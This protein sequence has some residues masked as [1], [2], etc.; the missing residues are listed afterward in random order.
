MTHNRENFTDELRGFALLGIVLVNAPFLG[1]SIQGFSSASIASPLDYAAAFFTLAFAQAKFYLLFSF[2][3]GYS[4]S[5]FMKPNQIGNPWPFRRRLFGLGILG[6]VHALF[7]FV[8]DILMLYALLGA[9]LFLMRK[10]PDRAV[11]RICILFV[12]LWIGITAV[13]LHGSSAGETDA[14]IPASLKA[15]DVVM[16][17][18][19]FFEAAKARITVFPF[20]AIILT[21]FNGFGVLA[22]FCLGLIAGRHRLLANFAD[23]Q[24]LWRLGSRIGLLL[25]VPTGLLS[26]YLTIGP[27][28]TLGASTL[29]E[30][31][32]TVLG[33]V[34]A[35]LLT[36]GYVSWLALLRQKYPDMLKFFRPAG[37]MS[38][39]GYLGESIILSVVFCSYGFGWFGKLGAASV[40][41]IAIF[42]WLL[43]DVFSKLWLRYFQYGPF[44]AGLRA[45]VGFGK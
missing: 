24:S 39:T 32:G 7:F 10:R 5:F 11:A 25:G 42:T 16:Q 15:F 9:V 40:M 31:G 23:Y 20:F 14:G 43:L 29:R 13:V 4:F 8:G 18:G 3:F 28:A 30:V 12:V 33:F 37:R 34:T 38:L 45:W 19:S 35:P 6:V 36:F 44:E 21:V 2:L 1:I 41:L 27:G 22:M 17:G 26:A